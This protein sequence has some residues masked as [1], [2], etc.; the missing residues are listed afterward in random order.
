M[1]LSR[2]KMMAGILGISLGSLAAFA[3]QCPKVDT[4]KGALP[5]SVVPATASTPATLPPLPVA[6]P[7][8][9]PST[10]VSSPPALPVIPASGTLPSLPDPGPATLPPVPSPVPTPP[11]SV[12]PPPLPMTGSFPPIDPV[13]SMPP[14]PGSYT[15][16]ATPAVGTTSSLPMPVPSVPPIDTQPPA[17]VPQV[18]TA[19]AVVPVAQQKYRI[20][21][22]VGEGEPVFEVRNGDHLLLKVI[23]EKVD[24]KSPEKGNGLSEVKA[25]GKV[26][27]TGFG[28]E[29]TCE[30]LELPGRVRRGRHEWEGQDSGQ[31]QARPRR[32]RTFDRDDEVQD[33]PEV[34]RGQRHPEAVIGLPCRGRPPWRPA[35]TPT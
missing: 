19:S 24:V 17:T 2:W 1:L 20:L 25:I 8:T 7:A 27:F 14:L 31:G 10:P 33:R 35:L 29:G 32:V 11:V 9:N 6:T 34:D 22:R 12:D 13:P 26:R 23:C 3:G 16:P 30:E 15:P 5:P 21:L 18:V 28:A 4:T